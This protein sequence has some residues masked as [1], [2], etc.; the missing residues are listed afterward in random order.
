MSGKT[1]TAFCAERGIKLTTFYNW[2]AKERKVA[3]APAFQE[4]QMPTPVSGR[5]V[6]VCLPNRVDV[7]IP[8]DSPAELSFVLREAARC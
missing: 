5:E 3:A 8:V 7:C 6:R 2:L 4:V 1:A